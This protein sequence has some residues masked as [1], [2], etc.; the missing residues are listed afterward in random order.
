MNPSTPPEN[1]DRA[2]RE[3]PEIFE[4]FSRAEDPEG[5][6][7]RSLLAHAPLSGRTVLELGYGTGRYTRELAPQSGC[8]L[9]VEPSPTLHSLARRACAGLTPTPFLLRA[10]GQALP[11]RAASVDVMIAAWVVVNLRPAIREAVQR[12][13][14]RV[15]RPGPGHGLWLIENHWNS[16]FQRCRGRGGEDEARLRH[17]IEVDGFRMVETIATK[18]RFPDAAEAERVLGY[19]CGEALLA[20]LRRRPTATLEHRVV[21]LHRPV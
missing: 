3:A 18:L 20:R 15:L 17:L 7:V 13:A 5:R 9:G 16:Q 11:L 2:Y 6:V 14:A 21:L 8:Y 19:L 4:A 10:R 12:E 1:W